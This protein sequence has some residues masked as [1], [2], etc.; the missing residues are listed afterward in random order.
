MSSIFSSD[1]WTVAQGEIEGH[2]AVIRMRSVLPS[3]G[4]RE[5]FS[6]L[7]V[8]TWDYA[9]ND[10][11]MPAKEV[12]ALMNTLEDALE[13]GCERS[14]H[15]YQALSLTCGGKKEWRYYAADNEEFLRSLNEDLAGHEPFPIEIQAFEDPEWGAL[16]E[17]LSAL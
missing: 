11:G 9:P 1:E 8:I 3:Q 17:Y 15:A 12:H 4:D 10:S 2:P 6:K 5:L 7:F 13:S 16:S 14:G